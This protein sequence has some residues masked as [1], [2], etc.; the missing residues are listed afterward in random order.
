M[1]PTRLD[2]VPK[3]QLLAL[4]FQSQ[5]KAAAQRLPRDLSGQAT[6]GEFMVKP[7]NARSR[8]AGAEGGG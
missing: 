3:Y 8:R 7:A 6:L 1:I 4:Y 5:D 2:S